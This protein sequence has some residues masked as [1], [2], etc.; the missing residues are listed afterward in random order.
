[1]TRYMTKT[2]KEAKILE[3][4][5]YLE[6]L[7]NVG[8]HGYFYIE[9]LYD[10]IAETAFG[11]RHTHA[12]RTVYPYPGDFE[13]KALLEKIITVIKAMESKGIIRISKSRKMFKL[14]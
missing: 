3:R 11:C 4:I 14:G 6:E 8:H 12:G 7:D 2:E 5:L 9:L 13:Y 1:M 10:I